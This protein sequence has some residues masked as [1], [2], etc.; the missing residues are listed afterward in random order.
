MIMMIPVVNEIQCHSQ[1]LLCGN[2]YIDEKITSKSYWVPS[3]YLNQCWVIVNWVLVGNLQEILVKIHQF[4]FK[5]MHLKMSSAKCHFVQTSI[6]LCIMR[7]IASFSTPQVRSQSPIGAPQVPWWAPQYNQWDVSFVI[8]TN[9][10]L[11]KTRHFNSSPT[12]ATYMR[13]WI[14]FALVQIMVWCLFSAKPLS[15]PM[16]VY[17]QMDP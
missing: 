3:H 1:P 9:G 11:N 13:Q 15:K 4:S 17:C 6:C 12:S 5:K 7:C 14:G 8:L 16:L 10:G 2:S